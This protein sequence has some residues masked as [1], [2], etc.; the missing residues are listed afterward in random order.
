MFK[1][2]FI[3]AAL[4]VL[5]VSCGVN[6]DIEV[7]S[8]GD[9]KEDPVTE[10]YINVSP[11]TLTIS[12][13]PQKISIIVE[14]TFDDLNVSVSDSS[15]I[16]LSDINQKTYIFTVLEN[17]EWE[18]RTATISFTGDPN[19][20]A[21]I[22]LT[23]SFGTKG[24]RADLI[25]GDYP[26]SVKVK[27]ECLMEYIRYT[28]KETILT[29]GCFYGTDS[30]KLGK[31]GK[32][33]EFYYADHDLTN[34]FSHIYP[35][36][37][38]PAGTEIFAK[39][40]YTTAN[41]IVYGKTIS[42]TI[43][44][45]NPSV[46]VY[47]IPVVFHVLTDPRIEGNQI[48]DN[49][50]KE[51]LA[52]TNLIFRGSSRSHLCDWIPTDT[53]ISF[54]LEDIVRYDNETTVNMV[55]Q[56]EKSAY[57]FLNNVTPGIQYFD[58]RKYINIWIMDCDDVGGVGSSFSIVRSSGGIMPGFRVD[59]NI[60]EPPSK[61]KLGIVIANLVQGQDNIKTNNYYSTLAHE[62]GH[63]LGLYHPFTEN[64]CDAINDYCNDTPNYN[65]A[66][67]MPVANQ[68]NFDRVGCNGEKFVS[69]NVMDY[70]FTR[71]LGFTPNQCERMHYAIEYGVFI[72]KGY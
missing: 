50:I 4:V 35:F 40:F 14:T 21:T 13:K 51:T 2:K 19:H 37:L 67:Y 70:F 10:D 57:K 60:T 71:R 16:K 34:K 20:S 64:G 58:P 65:R 25:D 12:D 52:S 47:E 44:G 17:Y 15:W 29:L 32:Y 31:G 6:P 33:F 30:T 45:T 69:T 46:S 27:V 68:M 43:F 49:L 59:D 23:Q 66:E 18:N 55:N 63:Y 24:I 8:D 42:R 26:F 41:H 11:S 62:L 56:T 54:R 61:S 48:N 3:I 36:D 7:P 9:G 22:K 72:P 39:P 28:T 5:F 1:Y 38:I 53:K